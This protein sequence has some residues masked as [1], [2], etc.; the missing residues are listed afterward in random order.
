NSP[1]VD[2]DHFALCHASPG[3]SVTCKIEPPQQV[4]RAV[5]Q[6]LP[7]SPSYPLSTRDA[8]LFFP[9]EP[10]PLV[11]GFIKTLARLPLTVTIPS[12]LPVALTTKTVKYHCSFYADHFPRNP[13]PRL[14]YTCETLLYLLLPC[15]FS[16]NKTDFRPGSPPGYNTNHDG[17]T[18]NHPPS[19]CS[20]LLV[21]SGAS[22]PHADHRASPCFVPFGGGG[23]RLPGELHQ[24]IP[25]VS[26]GHRRGDDG[27]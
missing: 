23:K 2:H 6:C 11:P 14:L 5:C 8:C 1:L 12:P 15:L 10:P 3:L 26:R 20:S 17:L 4:K 19:T 24:E 13:T 21:S 16:Q 25:E 22:S 7:E 27:H 9:P 18:L